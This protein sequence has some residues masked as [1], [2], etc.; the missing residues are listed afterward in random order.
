MET[1]TKQILEN[2]DNGIF[3]HV[4]NEIANQYIAYGFY[5]SS[6]SPS[7]WSDWYEIHHTNNINDILAEMQSMYIENEAQNS[8]ISCGSNSW[9]SRIQFNIKLFKKE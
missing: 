3:N 8:H 2:V 6:G 7:I 9:A 5:R 1:L 4:D